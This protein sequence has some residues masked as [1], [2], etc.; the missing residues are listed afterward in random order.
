MRKSCLCYVGLAVISWSLIL[1]ANQA[2]AG[3][4]LCHGRSDCNGGCGAGCCGLHGRLCCGLFHRGSARNEGS[5]SNCSCNGSYKFPVPPLSS[6][7][8]PGMYQHQLMTDYHSP[9]RFPPLKPYTDEK[10]LKEDSSA[11][12]EEP[13]NVYRPVSNVVDTP[14]HSRRGGDIERMSQK[15][16]RLYR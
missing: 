9:W 11:T 2:S 7:H 6:Y 15:V 16:E 3:G 10:L 8:W 12:F 14:R 1:F 5:W 13:L 4:L